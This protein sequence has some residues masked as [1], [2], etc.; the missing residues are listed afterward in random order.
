MLA[1]NAQQAKKPTDTT[2]QEFYR[3]IGE[4]YK[5]MEDGRMI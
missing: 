3:L 5:A 4:G 1:T 2:K